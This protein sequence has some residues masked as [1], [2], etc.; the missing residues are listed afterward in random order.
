M[1]DCETCVNDSACIPLTPSLQTAEFFDA[2]I[3]A[4]AD[5]QIAANWLTGDVTA[6]LRNI[7]AAS[8]LDC[9]L[10][11]QSLAELL[12]MISDSTIS[13]KIAKEVCLNLE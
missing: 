4:G 6:A 10:T 12:K 1:H 7:K 11:P 8:I 13:G 5:P 3:G 2:V 9:Q